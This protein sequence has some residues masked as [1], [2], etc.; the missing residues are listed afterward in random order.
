M[1]ISYIQAMK[2]LA[3]LIIPTFIL[4]AC[5][6]DAPESDVTAEEIA[7]ADADTIADEIIEPI[8]EFEWND[9]TSSGPRN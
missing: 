1:H 8:S 7:E 3:L 6:G 4:F 9:E 5:G 2:Y